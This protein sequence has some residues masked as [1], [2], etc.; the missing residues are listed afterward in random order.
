M[1]PLLV[2][3]KELYIC[4]GFPCG[5]AGKESVCKARDLG[6]IPR[7]GRS[8]KEGKGDPLQ[9]SG[10][11]DF[12]DCIVHGV[13]KSRTRLKRLS[14]S[15]SKLGGLVVKNLLAMQEPQETRVQSLSQ[16]DL[17]EK[18]MATH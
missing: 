12:M 2:F 9:C 15:S 18:G 4:Q 10:L 13:A 7:L 14:S 1:P 8:P 3:S 11:E 5:S 17:L 6:S 16:E